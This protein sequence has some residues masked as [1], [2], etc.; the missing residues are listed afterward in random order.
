MSAGRIQC[1]LIASRSGHVIYERFYDSFSEVEKAEIRSAFDDTLE[2][3]EI[4][5]GQEQVGRF[6]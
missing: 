6:K 4:V 5:D 1:L 2:E 3:D